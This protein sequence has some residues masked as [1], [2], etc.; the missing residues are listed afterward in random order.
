MSTKENR[1]ATGGRKRALDAVH[2]DASASQGSSSM[3]TKRASKRK[4]ITNANEHAGEED[5]AGENT[6]EKTKSSDPQI[7]P[8]RADDA[9][10]DVDDNS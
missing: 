7:T 4:R 3:P 10:R 1:A 2:N 5:K 9:R 6:T 8:S